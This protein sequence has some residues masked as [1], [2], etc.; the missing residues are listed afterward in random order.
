MNLAL[1]ATTLL[2]SVAGLA[3]VVTPLIRVQRT[4]SSG[5]VN[6]SLLGTLVVFGLGIALY[7]AIGRPNVASH[8]ASDT[9]S[10]TM[11]GNLPTGES[12]DA[13]NEKAASVASLLTGLEARLEEHPD[14]G[15]GW[16]LLAQSYELLGRVDDARTA[17]DKATALGI[18]DDE[19]ASKLD[20][21]PSHA[22]DLASIRGR[23]R[24]SPEIADSV[25]DDAVVYVIARTTD[26]PMPL[27]VLRRSASELPFDFE[28]SDAHS[29]VQG[30]GL[31][32]AGELAIVV[33]IS[34]SG[35]A[36]A[37]DEGLE[38][39]IHGVDPH[40]GKTL[41]ITIGNNPAQ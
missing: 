4:R 36:L 39:V 9:M 8:D 20:N 6:L 15:K 3:F 35:D 22:Q 14:D 29:M 31:S 37:M 33:G 38:A 18:S 1:L 5:S 2:M 24:V 19:F 27:A 13:Q 32:T 16:L 40:A 41:D 23:V 7:G 10:R 28:L 26:N 12:G 21:A 11:P 17:Y 25:S 30:A 34:S